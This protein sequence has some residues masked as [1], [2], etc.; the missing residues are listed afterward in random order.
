MQSWF[1]AQSGDG[2]GWVALHGFPMPLAP[3]PVDELDAV[4]VD[5]VVVALSVV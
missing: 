5:D 1:V 3:L 4:D 2:P